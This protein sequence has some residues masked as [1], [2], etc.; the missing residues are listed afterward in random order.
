MPCDTSIPLIAQYRIVRGNLS[1]SEEITDNLCSHFLILYE[2]F[3]MKQNGQCVLC[4]I[5]HHTNP[6]P[7]NLD[8]RV[9]HMKA[10]RKLGFNVR[11]QRLSASA[12]VE[13]ISYFATRARSKCDGSHTLESCLAKLTKNLIPRLRALI[14]R[15]KSLQKQRPYLSIP[16]ELNPAELD[17]H[18]RKAQTPCQSI[19][20]RSG[21]I[22][23]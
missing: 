5:R 11:S 2:V 20:M 18:F 8:L 7:G 12:Y 4:Q 13:E 15:N 14:S 17:K 9:C 10:F 19:S 22:V 3:D 6:Q 1:M 21:L 16:I 23:K